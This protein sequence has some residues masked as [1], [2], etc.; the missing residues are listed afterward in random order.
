MRTIV[1]LGSQLLCRPVPNDGGLYLAFHNLYIWGPSRLR[2][3]TRLARV[4]AQRPSPAPVPL[5]FPTFVFAAQ[6]AV[7][8]YLARPVRNNLK[9]KTDCERNALIAN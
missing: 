6:R 1:V 3:Q 4:R 7:F 5:A 8:A 2:S 9:D